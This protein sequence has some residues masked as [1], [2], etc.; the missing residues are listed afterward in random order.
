MTIDDL[1]PDDIAVLRDELEKWERFNRR[2]IGFRGRAWTAHFWFTGWAHISLGL[3]VHL[4]APNIELH[5]PFG[6]IRIGRRSDARRHLET[7]NF[8]DA[9][10]AVLAEVDAAP[11]VRVTAAPSPTKRTPAPTAP[12][13]APKPRASDGED[14]PEFLKRKR[15]TQ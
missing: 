1:T 13:A 4:A 11:P 5:V 10:R 2:A 14:I 8:F 6:F 12:A 7:L 15:R 9:A 3:H